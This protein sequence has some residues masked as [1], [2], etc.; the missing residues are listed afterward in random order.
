[1]PESSLHCKGTIHSL[2]VS[3]VLCYA[4]DRAL[5]VLECCLRILKHRLQAKLAF[6]VG[7][8]SKCPSLVLLSW[9]PMCGQAVYLHTGAF[10]ER[11]TVHS[12]QLEVS[13]GA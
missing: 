7:P 11:A 9:Y 5:V 4:C 6:D 3:E 13:E 1:M 2:V 10:G 8:I 12:D